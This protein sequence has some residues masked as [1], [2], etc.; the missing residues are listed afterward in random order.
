MMLMRFTYT[1]GAE[2]TIIPKFKNVSDWNVT[3]VSLTWRSLRLHFSHET[4]DRSKCCI[5]YLRTVSLSLNT[6]KGDL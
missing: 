3:Y 5:N 2:A 6:C 4:S 1:F